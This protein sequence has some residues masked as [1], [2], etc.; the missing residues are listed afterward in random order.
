METAKPQEG[1]NCTAGISISVLAGSII[2]SAKPQKGRKK[3]HGV[4][5]YK[6]RSRVQSSKLQTLRKK[7]LYCRHIYKCPSRVKVQ[8]LKKGKNNRASISISVAAGHQESAD[9]V[10]SWTI[11]T[12]VTAKFFLSLKSIKL[13]S[14]LNIKYKTFTEYILQIFSSW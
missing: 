4:H 6:C 10:W 3:C 14:R 5:I 2:E 13:L 9:H 1:K 7:K 8:N 12:V 11:Q